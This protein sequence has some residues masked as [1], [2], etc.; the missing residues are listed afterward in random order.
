MLRAK[1]LSVAQ[2]SLSEEEAR[3]ESAFTANIDYA[4]LDTPTASRLNSS[5]AENISA[6]V[7]VAVPL[8]TGGTVR[9]SVPMNRFETNNEFSVLNPAYES[10]YVASISQPLLRGA[11]VAANANPIRLAFYDLQATEA[12]TKLE[13]T[14]V[15]A[16]ADRVYWRLYAARQELIVR[17]QEYDLAQAQLERARRFVRAEQLAEVEII[18]AESG[19]ADTIEQIINAENAVR[20]RQR[21]LKKAGLG[22][23]RVR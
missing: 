11:G 13:I 8:Q 12:R 1:T 6:D 4:K 2:A 21:E 20:D 22:P 15:L 18:R 17:K 5:Q 7:G 14:R 19:V 3:F 10:D 23:E 9:F 16:E